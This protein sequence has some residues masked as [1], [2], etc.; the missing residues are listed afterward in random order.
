M[1]IRWCITAFILFQFLNTF[2]QVTGEYFDATNRSFPDNWEVMFEDIELKID[3]FTFKWS[4][5]KI[6]HGEENK[7]GFVFEKNSE[8]A[9]LKLI[10]KKAFAHYEIEVLPGDGYV[11]LED[12]IFENNA[13]HKGKVRLQNI[14][15]TDFLNLRFKIKKQEPSAEM[16]FSVPLFPYTEMYAKIYPGTGE[17]FI[18]R[19]YVYEVITNNPDNIQVD[20]VWKDLEFFSY[21][22]FN[23]DSKIFIG[24]IG[25]KLG[26][27]TLNIRIPLKRP[28]L[29]D[30]DHSTYSLPAWD[31]KFEIKRSPLSFL[32]LDNTDFVWDETSRTGIEIEME[33]GQGLKMENTYRLESQEQPG[34]YLIAEIYTRRRL[35]NGNILCW[36][37]I[38]NFHSRS[39][40]YL[41]LKD[42]DSPMFITNFDVSPKT[43]INR[44]ELQREGQDF[45]ESLS[46]FPGETV[47][48]KIEGVSLDRASF[49]FEDIK[50]VYKDTL[51]KSDKIHSYKLQIPK[52]ITKKR[53]I[54]YN[55]GL[56]T[57]YSLTINEFQK[58][59][60]LDFVMLSYEE[61][62]R[63]RNI[64]FNK[65][66]SAIMYKGSLKDILIRPM[67]NRIDDEAG[68]HGKQY[69]T[70]KITLTSPDRELVEMR[71]VE[72]MVIC[73]DQSS[74]R[75]LFYQD[76]DCQS[77]TFNINSILSRKTNELDG[78][79]RVEVEI[80]HRREKH[81][82]ESYKHRVEFILT[83]D[84]EFDID[85]SFPAGLL[86]IRPDRPNERLSSF[87]GVSLAALAQF[88]FFKPG[89]IA[90]Y[91]PYRIGVGTIAMNAFDFSNDSE[92]RGL[93]LVALGSLSPTRRNPK[94][95]LTLYF[96]GG[97]FL[98]NAE[99]TRTPPGWFFLIGPGIAVRL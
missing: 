23:E 59:R 32:A 73:P 33:D 87:S 77:G 79:S 72:N 48:I 28:V 6:D 22:L 51:L 65:I 9:N 31:Y 16:A 76:K 8:V 81:N 64:T 45:I 30:G 91:Q 44:I 34:G 97:Y 39:D 55:N 3:T 67:P 12:F 49:T 1:L 20:Q 57:G 21:R 4:E 93:A 62:G 26:A 25:K 36:L 56:S 41:Y 95:R 24:V 18:G 69:L 66:S 53:L 47:E 78:W 85:V 80:S 83:R 70:I 50:G 13:Y 7:L 17:L 92:D 61:N 68:L 90:K 60:P 98:T 89:Q 2:A 29:A 5:H 82:D 10:P 43:V 46:V 99:N 54:I 35:S 37:R 19:E 42:N 40:G 15:E 75:F 74:P 88:S 58:A 27:S 84:Y 94:L 52:D 86:Q 14:S 38:Y 11:I 63:E 96:G 71:T